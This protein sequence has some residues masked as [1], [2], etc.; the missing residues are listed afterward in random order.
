[1]DRQRMERCLAHKF[2]G[3]DSLL[4]LADEWRFGGSRIGD[5]SDRREAFNIMLSMTR[6]TD[7][8]TVLRAARDSAKPNST[9]TST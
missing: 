4:D 2:F 7:P 9:T 8:K 6:G 3:K 1:M 5:T